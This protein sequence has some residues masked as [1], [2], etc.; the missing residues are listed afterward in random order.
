MGRMAEVWAAQR[1]RDEQAEWES[2]A[3]DMHYREVECRRII[4]KAQT[5]PI[6]PDEASLLRW[7]SGI[8]K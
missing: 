8:S 5:E 7:A 3:A 1:E 4:E 2:Y 6:T